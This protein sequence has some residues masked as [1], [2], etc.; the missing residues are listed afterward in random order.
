MHKNVCSL[1]WKRETCTNTKLNWKRQSEFHKYWWFAVN[2]KMKV[3]TYK[4]D[5]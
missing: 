5:L 3:E 2:V 4:Y 1:S